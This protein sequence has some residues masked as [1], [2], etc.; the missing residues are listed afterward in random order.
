MNAGATS[1]V[2]AEMGLLPIV[3]CTQRAEQAAE[4]I[5]A[6]VSRGL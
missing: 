3:L 1:D 2:G 4:R 5:R 6:V